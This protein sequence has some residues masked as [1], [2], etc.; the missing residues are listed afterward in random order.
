MADGVHEREN[1]VRFERGHG[2]VIR[3]VDAIAADAEDAAGRIGDLDV[4][5]GVRQ[6]VVDGEP[7]IAVE[8]V[9]GGGR[10]LQIERSIIDR[11][12]WYEKA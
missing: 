7:E 12:A 2:V 3:Q 11:E 10:L 1:H 9:G 6:D 4:I 5:S 8:R